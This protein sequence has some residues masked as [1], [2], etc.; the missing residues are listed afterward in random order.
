MEFN[1]SATH[2]ASITDLYIEAA[3]SNEVRHGRD[4]KV[5]EA[6][7]PDSPTAFTAFRGSFTAVLTQYHGTNRYRAADAMH[8]IFSTPRG[9][10]TAF[11]PD[12]IEAAHEMLQ[13]KRG[14]ALLDQNHPVCL[15][16]D[17]E[18][19]G[20]IRRIFA[21]GPTGNNYTQVFGRNMPPASA[22]FLTALGKS[23]LPSSLSDG[24]FKLTLV[25]CQAESRTG[26]LALAEMI[27]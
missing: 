18:L 9:A 25:I 6:R 8:A 7:L 17:P 12:K 22:Q 15:D 19:G 1:D 3:K 5:L 20:G 2:G 26:G 23:E 10:K 4:P 11:H 27:C 21:A 16:W 13:L 24:Q 14:E